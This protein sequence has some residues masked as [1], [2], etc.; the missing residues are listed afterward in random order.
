MVHA[1]KIA[2]KKK[3]ITVTKVQQTSV[4]KKFN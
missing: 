2:Q 4:S 3:Q 1:M